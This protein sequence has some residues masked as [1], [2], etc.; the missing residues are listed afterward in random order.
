MIGK[1]NNR[2]L[3]LSDGTCPIGT[4]LNAGLTADAFICMYRFGLAID[5]LIDG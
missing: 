5:H 4:D 2:V 1:G 3:N